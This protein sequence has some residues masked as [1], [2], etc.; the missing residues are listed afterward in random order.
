MRAAD[1]VASKIWGGDLPTDSVVRD[2]LDALDAELADGSFRSIAFIDAEPASTGGCTVVGGVARL[3]G[4]CTRT[5]HRG[6]GAYRAVLHERLRVARDHGAQFALAKGRTNTSSPI[7]QRIGFD[8]Y[9]SQQCYVHH[10]SAGAVAT[11]Q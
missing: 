5:G 8:Q 7:L 9:G 4:A 6:R 3:W 10:A 11:L 2:R 1:L